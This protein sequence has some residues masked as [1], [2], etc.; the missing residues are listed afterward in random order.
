MKVVPVASAQGLVFKLG[1]EDPMLTVRGVYE[2]AIR[3]RD[4][5]KAE[6]FYRTV[7]GFEVGRRDEQR[8]WV[9]LRAGRDGMIVLQEDSSAWPRQHFAFTVAEAEI[10][11]AASALRA[12]G[13]SVAGPVVHEWIPARSLYFSDPDGHDLELC[14]PLEPG[15]SR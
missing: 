8:N 12:E 2:V 3:V 10:E 7:L 14:A 15:A 1:E 6:A 9:F 5:R 11:P 4:L 13:I